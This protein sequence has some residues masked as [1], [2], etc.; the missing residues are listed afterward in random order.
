MPKLRS[1]RKYEFQWEKTLDMLGGDFV[2]P[3]LVLP[4]CTANRNAC[5]RCIQRFLRGR[6]FERESRVR[7]RRNEKTALRRAASFQHSHAL[8]AQTNIAAING[9]AIGG[10]FALGSLATSAIAWRHRNSA[11]PKCVGR[12]WRLGRADYRVAHLGLRLR[13][14]RPKTIRHFVSVSCRKSA[15]PI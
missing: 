13:S 11:V 3:E 9:H 1:E 12:T 14:H 6:W 7:K 5:I 10:G 4:I 2:P 8:D 15:R